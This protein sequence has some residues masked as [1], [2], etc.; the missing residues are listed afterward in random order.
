MCLLFDQRGETRPLDMTGADHADAYKQLIREEN[1]LA[2][3]AT[4]NTP[5][6][7]QWYGFIPR[8]QFLGPAAAVLHYNCFS[9]A[10][11]SLARRVLRMP[12]VSYFDDFGI[13]APS[14]LV[15]P[16]LAAFAEPNE[17]LPVAPKKRKSEA[18]PFPEC[19][20]SPSAFERAGEIP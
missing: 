15:D 8:T 17:S 20:A 13:I 18:G 14:C 19:L 2:A 7:E 9:R 6:G 5:S 1:E 10:T 3:A 16:A 11:A 4:L 12:C